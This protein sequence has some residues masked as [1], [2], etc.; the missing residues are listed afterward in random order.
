MK[1]IIVV[2]SAIVIVLM[3]LGVS[4]C[5]EEIPSGLKTTVRG[6][7]IDTVKNKNIE[8][9]KVVAHACRRHTFGVS[10]GDIIDSARTNHLGEF[11]IQFITTGDAVGYEAEVWQDENFIYTSRDS[12]SAGKLNVLTLYARELNTLKMQVGIQKNSLSPIRVPGF[13]GTVI[14][15]GR[16]TRDTTVYPKVLPM[17]QNFLVFEAYD[18][19]IH[20]YNN[21]RISIDTLDIGLV[22]TTYFKKVIT[23]PKNWPRR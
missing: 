19:T 7:V 2:I 17:A 22:D 12:V 6:V 3:P 8:G 10:C 5:L 16:D 15:I 20:E 23:D 9:V 1:N 21:V 13:G 18:T 11:Q 14:T 4:S